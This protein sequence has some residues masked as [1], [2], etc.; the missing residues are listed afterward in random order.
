MN[1]NSK[2][3]VGYKGKNMCFYCWRSA[4]IYSNTHLWCTLY[5]KTCQSVASS[6][7]GIKAYLI[8]D[9]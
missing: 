5:N 2:Y 4:S 1:K 8:D 3:K 6:C 7:R 9:L